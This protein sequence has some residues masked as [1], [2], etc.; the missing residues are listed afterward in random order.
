MFCS[1]VRLH[2]T[3]GKWFLAD[4]T[5]TNVPLTVDLMDGKVKHRNFFFATEIDQ[6]KRQELLTSMPRGITG[7]SVWSNLQT[8]LLLFSDDLTNKLCVCYCPCFPR[9]NSWRFSVFHATLSSQC[10]AQPLKAQPHFLDVRVHHNQQHEVRCHE[11]LAELGFSKT[12]HA[13]KHNDPLQDYFFKT[14]LKNVY[15]PFTFSLSYL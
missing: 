1:H 7:K 8:P 3:F 9:I 2:V 6:R 12:I 10:C 11:E 4:R 13:P 15:L 14:N 5:H